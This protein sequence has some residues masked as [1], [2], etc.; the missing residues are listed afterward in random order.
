V[1][2]TPNI[3]EALHLLDGKIRFSNAGCSEVFRD[4]VDKPADERSA[5]RPKSSYGGAKA[6]AVSLV[7]NYKKS[8]GMFAC[9]GL[10]FNHDWPLR[11]ERFVT[12]TA[13]ASRIANA[14]RKRLRLGNLA[15]RRDFAERPRPCAMLNYAQANDFIIASDEAHL[16]KEFVQLAFETAGLNWRAHVDFDPTVVRPSDI[17]HSLG[18]AAKAKAKLD[19]QPTVRFPDI[20]ARMVRAETDGAGAAL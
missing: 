15:I 11:S 14:N 9:S 18:N 13:P 17:A 19:W 1:I 8:C 3:L 7:A 4:A 12:V 10:L 20:V 16:L 2:D 5:L 6:A